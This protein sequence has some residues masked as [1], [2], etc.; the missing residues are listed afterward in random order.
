M[1]ESVDN[2]K[3][4]IFEMIGEDGR[5]RSKSWTRERERE[6][7]R[8]RESCVYVGGAR[9]KQEALIRVINAISAT[10]SSDHDK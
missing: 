7:A 8:K 5:E 1:W 3:T 4:K 9:G 6:E 2:L 10:C